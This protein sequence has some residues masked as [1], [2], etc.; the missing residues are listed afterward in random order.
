MQLQ[1]NLHLLVL[2]N[3]RISFGLA[4]NRIFG[5]RSIR[6]GC[7]NLHYGNWLVCV[8]S[9]SYYSDVLCYIIIAGYFHGLELSL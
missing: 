6:F 9:L 8:L 3:C 1:Y 5:E 7:L 2:L 4:T